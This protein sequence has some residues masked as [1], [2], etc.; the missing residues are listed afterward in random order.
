MPVW[1]DGARGMMQALGVVLGYY[2]PDSMPGG[3]SPASRW[4]WLWTTEAIGKGTTV[5]RLCLQLKPCD[6]FS[7][8]YEFLEH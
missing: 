8:T 6:N 3:G 1:W 7:P 4:G 2:R 5:H